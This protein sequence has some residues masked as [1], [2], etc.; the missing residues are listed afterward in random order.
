MPR[1]TLYG[2]GMSDDA[3]TVHL[4]QAGDDD[5]GEF[6]IPSAEPEAEAATATDAATERERYDEM[7]LAALVSP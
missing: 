6:F 7:I 5:A 3:F 4:E 1:M 2:E